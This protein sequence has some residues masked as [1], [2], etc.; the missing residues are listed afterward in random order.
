VVNAPE[1]ERI[2][3]VDYL[4]PPG[5]ALEVALEKARTLAAS[6]AGPI[7]LT[8]KILSEGLDEALADEQTFQGLLFTTSDFQEGRSA[9]LEKRTPKFGG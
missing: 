6:A 9:F 4:A 1:G 3:L 2:G 8:K 7:E 5:K